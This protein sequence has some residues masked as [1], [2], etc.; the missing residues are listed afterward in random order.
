MMLTGLLTVMT[1]FFW[2]NEAVRT[3]DNNSCGLNTEF[4]LLS[5]PLEYDVFLY[6]AF[7]ESAH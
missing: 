2:V 6:K 3:R 4:K 1:V 5:F 7:D